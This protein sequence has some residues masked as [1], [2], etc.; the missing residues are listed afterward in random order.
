MK[1][2]ILTTDNREHFKDYS[3]PAPY[4]GTAPEAL[5]QGFKEIR[6]V[7]IHVLSCIRQPVVSPPKLEANIFF[8]SLL[9]RKPGWMTTMYQGC[10]RAIRNCL[11]EIGP[12][13]VHGQGSERE[14]AMGAVW[15]GFP[16]V[17]TIHGNMA[18]LA[19]LATAGSAAT[20]GWRPD[21]KPLLCAERP[22]CFAIQNTRMGWCVHERGGPGGCQMRSVSSSLAPLLRTHVVNAFC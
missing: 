1:V 20:A 19:R 5:L 12:Q 2:A 3:S 22:A 6:D 17:V 18:E 4:F 13:L 10:T 7:E 11:R 15:S 14:C 8:H 9:V 21:L 16:N